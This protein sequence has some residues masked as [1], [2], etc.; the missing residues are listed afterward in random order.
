MEYDIELVLDSKAELSETPIW[1]QGK[2]VLYWTDVFSGDFHIFDLGKGVD[3]VFNP[4]GMI[5]SAIPCEDGRVLLLLENGLN[6]FDPEKG[7]LEHLID[8]EPGRDENRLNDGRCDKAG[9]VWFS[10]MSKVY[11][12]DEYDESLTGSLYMVDTDMSIKTVMSDVN[13]LNGIGWSSDDK[14]MYIVDTHNFKLLA[15]DYDVESGEASG[16][17]ASCEIPSDFGYADGMCMDADDNVWIAH[18]VSGKISK[19][20]PR[21]GELIETVQMP[22]PHATCCGFG[23]ENYDVMFVT[24]ARLWIDEAELETM[25]SNAG[26][27]YTFKPGVQGRESYMFNG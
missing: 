12:G 9:R 7:V 10:T 20:N 18:W 8:P 11:G 27:I 23:G 4:G 24:T 19:W 17:S 14:R 3:K 22:V 6:L 2:K 1:H 16:C 13:Q 15:F 26:G 25:Y 5:G 21:T